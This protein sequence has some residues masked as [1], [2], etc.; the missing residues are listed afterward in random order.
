MDSRMTFALAA[1]LAIGCASRQT[2]GVTSLTSAEY[3]ESTSAQGALHRGS[4]DEAIQLADRA[5]LMGPSDPWAHYLRG[6][7]HSSAGDTEEALRAFARAEALFGDRD[8]HGRS[9]AVYGRARVFDRAGRCDEARVVYAQYAEIVRP[10]DPSSSEMA[11]RYAQACIPRTAPAPELTAIDSALMRGDHAG[12]LQLA[13]DASKGAL[14]GRDRA[15]VDEARGMALIGLGRT[16]DA[17]QAL[18]RAAQVF[19]APDARA[20]RAEILFNEARALREAARCDDARAAWDRYVASVQ[21]V[22]EA[23]LA[24][25]YAEQCP[26]PSWPKPEAAKKK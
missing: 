25:Q 14:S 8:K 13:N 16:N 26:G 20:K 18:D 7:A 11:M 5:A 2:V 21:T 15:W 9:L 6:A 19:D 22:D 12:A 10:S 17:V 23:R 1:L 4:Y 24:R 3:A